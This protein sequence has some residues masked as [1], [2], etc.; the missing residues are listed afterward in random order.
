MI[1]IRDC[2]AHEVGLLGQIEEQADKLFPAGFIPEHMENYPLVD[3]ERARNFGSVMLACHQHDIVG[4]AVAEICEDAYHL[5]LIAVL[6]E[7]GRQGIGS[8]LLDR[9]AQEAKSK[10]LSKISLTTFSNIE[11]NAPYYLKRGFKIIPDADA[12]THLQRI[13]KS[14]FEEGFC[15]RV[16]MQRTL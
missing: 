4:F 12:N 11:W 2:L 1:E 8:A 3:L 5:F 6:P 16:A 15:N 14:E 7:W 13:L 10:G 9:V